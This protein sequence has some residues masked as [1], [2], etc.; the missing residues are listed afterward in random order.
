M[1]SSIERE[2]FIEK[3]SYE[4]AIAS[5]SGYNNKDLISV[6]KTI[7]LKKEKDLD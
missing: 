6:Y 4:E 7:N 1:A 2:T 3:A 5:S